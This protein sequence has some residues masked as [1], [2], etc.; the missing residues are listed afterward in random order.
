[1]AVQPKNPPDIRDLKTIPNNESSEY[2]QLNTKN[3]FRSV[4]V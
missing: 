3:S 4:F 2:R 1:V